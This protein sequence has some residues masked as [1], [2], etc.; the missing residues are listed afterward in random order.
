MMAWPAVQS[1]S[2]DTESVVREFYVSS[3]HVHSN[4]C[5]HPNISSCFISSRSCSGVCLFGNSGDVNGHSVPR[6]HSPRYY[7]HLPSVLLT[8]DPSRHPVPLCELD[9]Y[10]QI[11]YCIKE[12]K[13]VVP[14]CILAGI[15]T[16]TV[17][18][19]DDDDVVFRCCLL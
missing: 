3:T 9:E 6:H 4:R 16:I 5:L 10:Y 15:T 2:R 7:Y 13:I 17:C 19:N 11:R 1:R 12:V 18:R 8:T 14:L